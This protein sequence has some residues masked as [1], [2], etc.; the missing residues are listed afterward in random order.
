[1]ITRRIFLEGALA[2]PA[3][4]G[5][6]FQSWTPSVAASAGDAGSHLP[7]YAVIYERGM[8]IFAQRPKR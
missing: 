3:L 6:A 1:M 8:A 5:T 7:L 4:A 2:G